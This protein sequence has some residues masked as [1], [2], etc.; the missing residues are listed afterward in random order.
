MCGSAHKTEIVQEILAKLPS[1]DL[2]DE[3]RLRGER[4]YHADGLVTGFNDATKL[5]DCLLRLCLVQPA[6]TVAGRT[7]EPSTSCQ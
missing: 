7:A 2:I 5:F 1:G 3:F 4:S 6:S